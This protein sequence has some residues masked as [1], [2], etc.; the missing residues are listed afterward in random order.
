MKYNED[1]ED[2]ENEEE[3]EDDSKQTKLLLAKSQLGQYD[4]QLPKCFFLKGAQKRA[5]KLSYVAP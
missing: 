4:K 2:G 1:E 5:T 3:Q